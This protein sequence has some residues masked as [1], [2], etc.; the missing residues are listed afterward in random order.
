MII[1]THIHF[2]S[3]MNVNMK[4]KTVL[5][6]M[7]KYN[8]SKAIVSNIQS[9]ECDYQQKLLPEEKQIPMISSAKATID[10]AKDNPGKIYAAIWV[11]PLQESPSAELEYYLKVNL[12]YV[13]AIKINPFHSALSLTDEKMEP[14]IQLARMLDVPV[15][16]HTAGDEYSRCEHV[17]K[18]AKQFPDV[19]FVMAHLE[20][21]TNNERAIEIC[22]EMENIY[23]DTAWVPAESTIKFI[24]KCGNKKLMFGSDSPI[25]GLDTYAKN[26]QGQPSLY[27]PY[28]NGKL[29]EKLNDEDFENL[30]WKNAQDFYRL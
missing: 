25:D 8:I 23:G 6:A 9:I 3:M 19:R 21:C 12:E 30:M 15:I 1:D 29:K 5:M 24:K 7:E 28:F 18:A 22:S 26:K 17:L 20:L 13:K 11:K 27:L 16:V 2:G 4:K 14:Y 10:F